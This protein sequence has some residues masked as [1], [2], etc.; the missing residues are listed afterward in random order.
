M[1]V[2]PNSAAPAA[3]RRATA[4][5]SAVAGAAW[6]ST[7]EPALVTCPATSNRSL[8]DTA[9]PASTWFDWLE[10]VVNLTESNSAAAMREWARSSCK[11]VCWLA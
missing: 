1:L 6:A 7:R 10:F 11:K 9:S 2:R 8:T 5:Q 3:L 4:G